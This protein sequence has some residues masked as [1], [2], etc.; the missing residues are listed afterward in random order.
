M[1]ARDVASQIYRQVVAKPGLTATELGLAVYGKDPVQHSIN[2]GC[3]ILVDRGL[4]ERRGGISAA[5]PFR[6]YPTGLAR[7][8]P[9]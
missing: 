5:D 4:V 2:V 9:T 3:Q 7:A 6:Y 8:E 1:V